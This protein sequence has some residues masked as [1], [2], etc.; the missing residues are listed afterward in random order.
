MINPSTRVAAATGVAAMVLAGLA[1]PA[2]A[3]DRQAAPA[4]IGAAAVTCGNAY[5][6]HANLDP[7]KGKATTK[8]AVHTGPYGDCTVTGYL[9]TGDPVTF[10]CYVTNS[11]GNRWTW[12][13]DVAGNSIGWVYNE[14]LNPKGATWSCPTA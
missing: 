11:Y 12:V 8:A 2:Q 6:P 3:A 5:W 4:G 10:D 7:G 9:Y 13:R 14:Y 1:G